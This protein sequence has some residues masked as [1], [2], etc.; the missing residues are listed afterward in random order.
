MLLSEHEKK[1]KGGRNERGQA[2]A[3]LLIVSQMRRSRFMEEP[4]HRLE[5][6]ERERLREGKKK[7]STPPEM[8]Q[9]KNPIS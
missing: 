2:P 4:N 1:G 3:R 7:K 8:T 5:K 9:S 6:R